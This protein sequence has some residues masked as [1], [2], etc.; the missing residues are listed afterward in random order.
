MSSSAFQAGPLGFTIFGNIFCVSVT[1]RLHGW[2]MLGVFVAG[3]CP[4]RTLIS[5]SFEFM[6][7]NAC[8]HRQDFALYSIRKSSRVK[9]DPMLIPQE[10]KP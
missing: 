3:I 2:R 8:K 5:G 1:F 4:V 6:Q 7:W 10:K 9:F